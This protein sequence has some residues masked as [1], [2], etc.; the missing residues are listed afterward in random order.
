[1]STTSRESGDGEVRASVTLRYY[2]TAAI[3]AVRQHYVTQRGVK[4]PTGALLVLATGTGKTFTALTMARMTIANGGRVLWIAHRDEL[5]Q[6]PAREW[7]N[8]A[9]FRDVGTVGVVQASDNDV[10]ADLVIASTNT[11]GRKLNDEAGRL[12]QIMTADANP[13]RLVVYDECHHY[14]D[15]GRGM[16]AKLPGAIREHAARKGPETVQLLGLTAT[17]ERADGRA[18]RGLWGDEPAYV[19][20]YNQAIAEGYLVPPVIR[21]D[22]L[23]MSD[24]TVALIEQARESKGD[25][26]LRELAKS[27]MDDGIVEWTCAAADRHLTGRHILVFCCDLQQ[28]RATAAGLTDAGRKAVVVSGETPKGQRRALLRQFERGE[29]DALVNCT[30]LTEGTDLPIT[31][32]LIM[33][34]PFSSKPLFI[35]ALGRGLRTCQKTGKTDCVVVDL[36]GATEEHSLTHAVAMLDAAEAKREPFTGMTM[37]QIAY[38]DGK[39]K[40]AKDTQVIV[41]PREPDEDGD[42][43]LRWLVVAIKAGEEHSV[44]LDEPIPVARPRDVA[45]DGDAGINLPDLLRNRNR[46]T[47][48]WLP[49]PGSGGIAWVAGI[50]SHGNVWLV[51]V[52]SGD[53]GWMCYHIPKRARNPRPIEASPLP[54]SFASALGDDLF[55]QA[56][57]LVDKEAKWRDEAP[58]P[59][60]R[61]LIAKHGIRPGGDTRGDYSDAISQHFAGKFWDRHGVQAFASALGL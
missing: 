35:Q 15:D 51:E 36:L 56:S 14:A 44:P 30:V 6:Q 13:I 23:V 57:R 58:R 2:Q 34:R 11:I 18:L 40:L 45:A 5:V 24:E 29:I 33:A 10:S 32:G 55:R 3:D 22:R 25:D 20:S 1:M 48:R 61:D 9:Q 46:V 38:P 37:R 52:D 53:A 54:E 8:L 47:A 21:L 26:E 16:F 27:L 43:D 39:R 17:P 28:A 12:A 60:Q 19:Y 59:A 42:Q 4:D 49:V 50:G 31:D 7:A 41:Q